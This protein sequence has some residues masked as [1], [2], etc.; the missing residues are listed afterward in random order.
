MSDLGMG[1]DLGTGFDLATWTDLSFHTRVLLE[2][3][4]LAGLSAFIGTHV[5]D[6]K[7]SFLTHA[8][9]HATFPG[10]AIAAALG[11][12]LAVG[13]FVASCAVI[14]LLTLLTRHRPHRVHAMTGLL[15]AAGFALGTGLTSAFLGNTSRNL[16]A[17]LVGQIVN[18]TNTDLVV[19]FALLLVTAALTL[20]FHR[21]LT[22]SAFDP[23]SYRAAGHRTTS[24]SA[25]ALVLVA[26]AAS[27]L[28]SQVGAILAVSFL[29]AAPSAAR[30]LVR[31]PITV[32]LVSWIIG[33]GA[34]LLGATASEHVNVP[35]GPAITIVL[36]AVTIATMIYG[37]R[38]SATR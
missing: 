38:V 6:R 13:G 19:S 5:L 24:M 16:E 35:T 31:G 18:V 32:L 2:V 23:D 12:Q 37:A 1:F 9:G 3:T 28:A 21:R 30:A 29:V 33:E 20:L 11:V 36:G 7:L 10:I 34:G 8:L 26:A 27:V 4:I 25:L 14:G 15:L 17:F 22:F